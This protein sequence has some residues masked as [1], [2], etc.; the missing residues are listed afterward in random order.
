MDEGGRVCEREFLLVCYVCI[1]GHPLPLPRLFLP[2]P[3]N[4]TPSSHPQ[5]Q[6]IPTITPHH[7]TPHAIRVEARSGATS[8]VAG[9]VSGFWELHLPTSD[10]RM[11]P[12]YVLYCGGN[13]FSLWLPSLRWVGKGG[14]GGDGFGWL[15][16][17][18]LVCVDLETKKK[19]KH[20][21]TQTHNYR[22]RKA[23]E[24]TW[25]ACHRPFLDPTFNPDVEGALM[26]VH[27]ATSSLIF[28]TQSCRQP[29]GAAP[30]GVV[31]PPRFEVRA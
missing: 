10:P 6:P 1:R 24:L 18:G 7:T 23:L 17:L 12:C 15:G 25:A 11:R 9:N 20:Q 2:H 21:H 13:G 8:K 4:P 3:T 14:R 19:K 22:D 29:P 27:D 26:G 16:L 28:L 30:V 31:V 5:P